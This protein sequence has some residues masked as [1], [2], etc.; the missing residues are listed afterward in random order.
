MV[1]MALAISFFLFFRYKEGLLH[2]NPALSKI[3][4][5]VSASIS[6]INVALFVLLS[7][8]GDMYEL[9]YCMR[10]SWVGFTAAV[11]STLSMAECR[12][13]K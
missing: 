4:F 1:N 6:I 10:L 11:Y 3:K 7:V 5:T 9:P 8:L 13:A 12:M 2:D